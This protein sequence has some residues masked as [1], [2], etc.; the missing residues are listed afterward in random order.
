MKSMRKNRS[1][2]QQALR[3]L[4]L[5]LV[6]LLFS[7]ATGLF[8]FLPMQARRTLEKQEAVGHTQV[9]RSLSGSAV[10]GS[11]LE[12]YYLCANDNVVMLAGTGLSLFGWQPRFASTAPLDDD[13]PVHAAF[14]ISLAKDGRRYFCVFG[15]V[16]D[17]SVR[18]IT[19]EGTAFNDSRDIA[20]QLE[21]PDSDYIVKNGKTYFL[22][23]S[24]DFFSSGLPDDDTFSFS[25]KY[26]LIC[27]DTDMHQLARCE[28]GYGLWT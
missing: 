6:L 22:T 14:Q 12:R 13:L 3:S 27:Y 9:I 16:D 10:S 11:P 7:C 2:R 1:R 15:Q 26:I 4:T 25:S 21:I 23:C 5:L 24:A 8:S 18:H 19:V 28:I 17:P 20:I